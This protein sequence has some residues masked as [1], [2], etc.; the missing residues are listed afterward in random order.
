[1][2]NP[3][4]L[5]VDDEIIIARDLEARL[6]GMGYEVVDIASS[7]TEAIEHAGKYRPD[8]ILMDIVLKGELDGIEA[9][10]EI[11]KRYQSPV[12]FV[13]AYTDDSTLARAMI[14][15]PFGY[16]VKPFLEREV[17][18]NIEMALY[19]H[20]ME[21]KIRRI[22]TWF[23]HAMEG[24]PEGVI[25]ADREHQISVLNPVGETITAWPRELA[26]GRKLGEVL[27][28]MDKGGRP[29]DYEHV[30]E[31]PIVC[32]GDETWLV[33]REGISV[34]LE[35]MTS[36]VRDSDN[37]LAGTISVFRDAS[38][39]R[40]R[41]LVNLVSEVSLA[42]AETTTM[43]GMLQL[44]MESIVRNL[45]GTFALV[46]T[47]GPRQDLLLLE[48]SSA[49]KSPSGGLRAKVSLGQCYI[50]RVASERMPFLTNNFAKDALQV[51]TSWAEKERIVACAAYPLMVD[52]QLLGVV[53]MYSQRFLAPGGI[54]AL[55]AI[56]NTIAVG[57]QRKRVE[58]QLRHSQK[59]EA[60]GMLAGG[61]AHDFN[62]LLTVITGYCEMLQQEVALSKETQH[63]VREVYTAGQRATALTKQLLTF[64]RKQ[65]LSPAVLD[66]NSAIDGME[67]MLRRVIGEDI[68]LSVKHDDDL[69]L[70]LADRGQLEQVL[71]NLVLNARDAMPTGGSIVI[72]T[73]GVE[74]N[75]NSALPLISGIPSRYVLLSVSD[76]GTGIPQAQLQ[77]IFEPFFT[78]KPAG[79]GTGLGLST[80]ISIVR[81]AGGH[82]DV[83]SGEGVGTTFKL[84]FPSAKQSAPSRPRSSAPS[85]QKTIGSA[86]I[87]V[88]EDEAPVRR[89]I[90]IVLQAA[91]YTVI[92]ATSGA[93]ALEIA[94]KF[95]KPIH[96][97]L[98][99]VVMPDLSGRELAEH[100][101]ER[102]PETRIVFMSGYTDDAIVRHGIKQDEIEFI[103]KP[104]TS[105]GLAAKISEVLAKPQPGTAGDS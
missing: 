62:N 78:T 5:V 34:P 13:T 23:T 19:K 1:M 44:C 96:L 89:L 36:G 12:I 101:R 100:W 38:G 68:S 105:V 67:T 76:T 17:K 55:E 48:A 99:D 66:L 90:A 102:H 20:R 51:D 74:L 33:D 53:A 22:E 4:I 64:S 29:I 26:T 70:I 40:N 83:D 25:V 80:V 41:A 98:T 97:L 52:D 18:A 45:N 10:A 103:Q 60:L 77:N 31:G 93:A 95:N 58:E 54:D 2:Q 42:A 84:Y 27:K 43:R 32:L 75:I 91:G 81:Q 15:E 8:L 92:E 73:R 50:G 21:K 65:S 6:Q 37:N 57:I 11:R 35:S 3:R 39:K 47:L 86:T 79:Q 59:I 88:V 14:T 87:L 63:M 7:G 71:A 94:A 104:F 24:S 46:W 30:T 85:I 56:A 69:D 49:L 82:V 72:E 28:L 16:I 9:A 61:I